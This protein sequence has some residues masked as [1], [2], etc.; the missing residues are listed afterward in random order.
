MTFLL[1]LLIPFEPI[2]PSVDIAEVNVFGIHG[3]CQVILWEW[4]YE[5]DCFVVI[6]WRIVQ[7]REQIDKLL[8]QVRYKSFRETW[9]RG[10][11]EA[12]NRDIV[13]QDKRRVLR[14]KWSY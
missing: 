13:P 2:T 11:P 3:T 9:T 8:G 7:N 10:D 5:H 14:I 6:A 12:Q 1:L 4:S